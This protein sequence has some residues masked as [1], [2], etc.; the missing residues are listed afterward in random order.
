[1]ILLLT[2]PV[3]GVTVKSVP[4]HTDAVSLAMV[5]FGFTVTVTVKVAP[6]QAPN[7]PEVGVT[8]YTTV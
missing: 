3:V 5:G 4:L 7:V 1:M 8:V 6:G 2:P